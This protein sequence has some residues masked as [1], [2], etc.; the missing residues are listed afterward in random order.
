[1][2]RIIG[3]IFGFLIK[4]IGHALGFVAKNIYISIRRFSMDPKNKN[5]IWNMKSIFMLLVCILCFVWLVG[6]YQD[7]IYG[8]HRVVFYRAIPLLI[9]CFFGHTIYSSPLFFKNTYSKP[10][11]QTFLNVL[12]SLAAGQII[13]KYVGNN[14]G[15]L[16]SLGITIFV[17]GI[18]LYY[19]LYYGIESTI[20][21]KLKRATEA[22]SSDK[23]KG[24]VKDLDKL[25][26]KNIPL[27]D[28]DKRGCLE[29]LR[30][31]SE[32]AELELFNTL[33]T[34]E[35]QS[36]LMRINRLGRAQH[37]QII[38]GTGSGKTLLSTNLVV[39]DLLNDYIGTTIIEPKGSYITRLANFMDRVNRPYHRLD[40]LH[41]DS[42]AINPFFVPEGAEV[43]PMIEANVSAF[44]G[45]LG[46]DTEQYFQ[47]RQ[48]QLLRVGIKALKLARGN[49]CT[50]NDLERLILPTG[51]EFRSELLSE[52]VDDLHQ[53]PELQEY[54]RTMANNRL[55]EHAMKTYSG[56]YDYLSELTSNKYIQKIFC[57]PSTFNIDDVL[58][59]GKVVLVNGAYGKLQTLTYTVGRLYLNLLKASVFR[60]D[61]SGDARPHS[62]TID[63]AEMFADG[64]F[65]TF[66]EMSREFEAYITVIHQGNAQLSDVSER[67]EAMVKQNAVQKFIM[68]GLENEDAEYYAQM[69]GEEYQLGVS[70]GTDEMNITGFQTRFNEEKRFNVLPAEILKLKGFNPTTGEPGEC[71]FRGVENNVRLDTVK[72]LV[73]PLPLELFKPVKE[74]IEID[75]QQEETDNTQKYHDESMSPSQSPDKKKRKRKRKRHRGQQELQERG[76]ELNGEEN[77]NTEKSE[78]Q[79]KPK[80]KNEEAFEK[81][82]PKIDMRKREKIV[83]NDQTEISGDESTQT[84]TTTIRNP[85]WDSVSEEKHGETDDN[86]VYEEMETKQQERQP[87]NEVDVKQEVA[88]TSETEPNLS[89]EQDKKEAQSSKEDTSLN[90]NKFETAKIGE[91]QLHVANKVRKRITPE[92]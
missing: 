8:I 81:N 38:G 53:V 74:D 76:E 45:Y 33:P 55:M 91:L 32:K 92:K 31:I 82:R 34:P 61:I 65:S 72:G 36:Q 83:T 70:T 78:K 54:T 14:K 15:L 80:E 46:P 90:E 89:E 24:R 28:I 68:A 42:D 35:K 62:I 48:T 25:N 52:L 75:E 60:R 39:Q 30:F 27:Q 88:S 63:E 16:I 29:Y 47:S 85:L 64:E 71:L 57:R 79:P 23:K 26:F 13:Q 44:H 77:V 41:P 2:V 5:L 19:T 56:L 6:V 1:M 9:V 37:T 22:N 59:N 21:A 17:V 86:A 18:T 20:Y 67:L 58:E 7:E 51:D 11:I 40:P 12:S 66:L 87:E 3:F 4:A 69:F 84:E 73:Y 50:Y 43:E 49:D 10:L